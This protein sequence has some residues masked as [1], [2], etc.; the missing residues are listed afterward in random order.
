MSNQHDPIEDLN[1]ALACLAR[2]KLI[3]EGRM[4]PRNYEATQIGEHHVR[5]SVHCATC[6]ERKHVLPFVVFTPDKGEHGVCRDCTEAMLARLPTEQQAREAAEYICGKAFDFA[7]RVLEE[8]AVPG[9][10]A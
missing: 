4:A 9:G 10:E 6:G 8:S 7:A 1:R 3:A 2:A 5:V